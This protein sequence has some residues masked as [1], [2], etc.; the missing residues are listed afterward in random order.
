MTTQPDRLRYQKWARMSA[1][2]TAV[3]FGI[4]VLNIIVG[5]I[6]IVYGMEIFHFGSVAEFLILLLV[7]VTFI[8]AALIAEAA[9]KVNRKPEQKE[10]ST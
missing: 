5:K 8:V 3:F 7:S 2:L 9:W 6:N 1:T 4:Y 10:V